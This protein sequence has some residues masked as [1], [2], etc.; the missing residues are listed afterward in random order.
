[1]VIEHEEDWD[2]LLDPVLFAIRTSVQE[3]TKF[4]PFFLMHGRE[5]RFPLEAENSEI[6]SVSQLG[7]VQQAVH[8]LK[9]MRNKV[10][11][12]VKENIE[13]SQ[14]RQKQQYRK[15]K[16]A[17]VNSIQVGQTVLRL[18]MLKRTMKGHK[19]EDTWLGPYRV[20]EMTASGGCVLRC[21]KTNSTMKR[22]VN[23]SQLKIYNTPQK[24]SELANAT[25]KDDESAATRIKGNSKPN[26]SDLERQLFDQSLLRLW[27]TGAIWE[28]W[29]AEEDDEREVCLHLA[30]D[31]Y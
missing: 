12:Q 30:T 23:I 27:H 24:S 10:F 22:K 6:T 1:M 21:I 8:H 19:M 25:S 13:N 11:P 20:I 9:E 16:G 7:D 15:R 14:E 31:T 4:T 3:S 29:K 28:A 26:F 5:A 2:E 18:N 17:V